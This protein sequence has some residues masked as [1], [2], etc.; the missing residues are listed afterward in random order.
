MDIDIGEGEAV[1]SGTEVAVSDN[2]DVPQAEPAPVESEPVDYG[3]MTLREK[4]RA[5]GQLRQHDIVKS[6]KEIDAKTKTE[7]DKDTIEDD[8]DTIEDDK[9][10]IEDDKDT[11]TVTQLEDEKIKP[12]P[13]TVTSTINIDHKPVAKS[14]SGGILKK[15]EAKAARIPS[16][17][18]NYLVTLNAALFQQKGEQNF[19][20]PSSSHGI[21]KH[22]Q[23][24]GS[25]DKPTEVSEPRAVDNGEVAGPG[26]DG[27]GSGFTVGVEIGRGG[28][29]PVGSSSAIDV[30]EKEH[31]VNEEKISEPSVASTADSKGSDEVFQDAVDK[32][33]ARENV[34]NKTATPVSLTKKP[35]QKNDAAQQDQQRFSPP[36]WKT[37]RKSSNENLKAN[38]KPLQG[39]S[40]V[41]LKTNR[42]LNND[43]HSNPKSPV[44]N[45]TGGV[46]GKAKL[47]Q[48][49]DVPEK[50]SQNHAK[51][52]VSKTNSAG[53]ELKAVACDINLDEPVKSE[54]M[55]P[56]RKSKNK[57][58]KSNGMET[59]K[60]RSGSH[61]KPRS[62]SVKD[63]T[64]NENNTRSRSNSKRGSKGAVREDNK[65]V[66]SSGGGSSTCSESITVVPKPPA[67]VEE[68]AIVNGETARSGAK[69]S[70]GKDLDTGEVAPASALEIAVDK[71]E[72]DAK[73]ELK[74]TSS[75]S[76][77]EF[78][79]RPRQNSGDK[80]AGGFD[81][82]LTIGPPKVPPQEA[83]RVSKFTSSS[84]SSLSDQGRVPNGKVLTSSSAIDVTN[85]TRETTQ[86]T[87][88]TGERH[89][90]AQGPKYTP[91]RDFSKYLT[92]EQA[93]MKPRQMT[94]RLSNG[95]KTAPSNRQP[96]P[97]VVKRP[98]QSIPPTAKGK[99]LA[100]ST[101]YV[102]RKTFGFPAKPGNQTEFVT[103]IVQEADDA[104]KTTNNRNDSKRWSQS[105]NASDRSASSAS[106]EESVGS[107]VKLENSVNIGNN[108]GYAISTEG[109]RRITENHANAT[110]SP[111]ASPVLERKW[112]ATLLLPK[113]SEKPSL[114]KDRD[115]RIASTN[116]PRKN[117]FTNVRSMFEG[118]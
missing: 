103:K 96:Q 4:R 55:V 16:T 51:A 104:T 28:T 78:K 58:S 92:N 44:S 112:K 24:Q 20:Q 66:G 50:N 113:D 9:D 12:Q 13:E 89:A 64:K 81:V 117:K 108:G 32:D 26:D 17:E 40:N 65:S 95:A 15:R 84:S 39:V 61:S 57:V 43:K 60:S 27:T 85:H 76:L 56:E 2:E 10:T 59:S 33:A 77:T 63:H 35:Q 115:V 93:A 47:F 75:H 82:M 88:P 45:K 62:G 8:K 34:G 46:L 68:K 91:Q 41:S 19:Q 98:S 110:L 42:F 74:S 1:E 3:A 14:A 5:R 54:E 72:D 67:T 106:S 80:K 6:K 73:E 83:A 37:Q 100:V 99:K 69:H 101:V 21:L 105:S 111:H 31:E 79:I 109:Q 94:A 25:E 86:L 23:W 49:D 70:K 11:S 87:L 97:V 102:P 52:D 36:P 53:K 29:P 18:D 30:V 118:K 114:A 22:N 107:S 7:D 116:V 71:E 90:P 38:L 48:K